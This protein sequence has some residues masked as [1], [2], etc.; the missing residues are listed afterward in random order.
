MSFN[1]SFLLPVFHNWRTRIIKSC[2]YAYRVK[3]LTYVLSCVC[4]CVCV[5]VCARAHSIQLPGEHLRFNSKT[6]NWR[7]RVLKA[8]MKQI[9]IYDKICVRMLS[10]SVIPDPLWPDGLEPARLLCPWD[11]PDKNSEVSCHFLLRRSS[12]PRDRTLVSCITGRF[13]TVWATRK[14][15]EKFN[16]W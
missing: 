10:R 11:S 12:Q 6:E 5:C 16:T 15:H 9:W 8:N 14:A 13:F 1:C 7:M 2:C 3:W 4:V